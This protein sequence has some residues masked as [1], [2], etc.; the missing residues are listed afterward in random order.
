MFLKNA[1]GYR[2]IIV[3]KRID[4]VK[5][6]LSQCLNETLAEANKKIEGFETSI[7]SMA[8]KLVNKFDSSLKSDTYKVL[9]ISIIFAEW[10]LKTI[11][12]YFVCK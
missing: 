2:I 8:R 10:N 7:I 5:L 11:E 3:P 9:F 12:N 1:S 6:A 4:I